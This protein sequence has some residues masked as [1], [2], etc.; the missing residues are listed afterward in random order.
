[1]NSY[2]EFISEQHHQQV[3]FSRRAN[4]LRSNQDQRF[5]TL[6]KIIGKCGDLLIDCGSWMKRASRYPIEENSI[7]IYSQN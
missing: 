3:S 7:G 2:Y 5:G 1:M 4:Y 6:G